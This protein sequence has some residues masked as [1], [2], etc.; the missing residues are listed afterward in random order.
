MRVGMM[1]YDGD[2]GGLPERLGRAVSYYRE[3][4]GSR[5]NICYVHASGDREQ[6]TVDGV[7][8][9]PSALVLPGHMWLGVEKP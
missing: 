7:R 5:P 8:V 9:E 6:V 3:K 4:Y 1:W 2:K